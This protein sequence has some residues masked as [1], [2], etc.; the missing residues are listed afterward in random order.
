VFTPAA[1]TVGA[2]GIVCYGGPC[3]APALN[4]C[5]PEWADFDDTVRYL[6]G[7]LRENYG[8]DVDVYSFNDVNDRTG[9][10]VI[11]ALTSAAGDWD[12]L[13]LVCPECYGSVRPLPPTEWGM[14]GCYP[15]PSY[16]HADCTPLC[17]VYGPDGV[18]PA[19]PVLDQGCAV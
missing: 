11:K 10:E 8:P 5:A 12:M 4:H 17:P 3:D 15:L 9:G 13:Y 6:D 19:S 16:A 7:W 14:P 18:Q 1:C 2:I